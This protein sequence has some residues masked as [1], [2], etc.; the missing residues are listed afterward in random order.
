MLIPSDAPLDFINKLLEE[1][2]IQCLDNNQI[3]ILIRLWKQNTLTYPNI[4]NKLD[5][6]I[7]KIKTGAASMWKIL[8]LATEKDINKSNFKN[9]IIQYMNQNNIS[10]D[11]IIVGNTSTPTH[12]FP[13]K[14]NN[15]N[16]RRDEVGISPI[17]IA[18]SPD[19]VL[20]LKSQFYIQRDEELSAYPVIKQ[21]GGLV[22]IKGSSKSGKTSF[23]SR[24]INYAHGHNY[25]VVTINFHR[26]DDRHFQSVEIFWKW[27]CIY[28]TRELSLPNHLNEYWF[29]ED[30]GSGNA[31]FYF[32][33]YLL[34]VEKEPILLALDRIDYI[35]NYPK[36]SNEFFASLRSWH[37]ERSKKPWDKLHYIIVQ[38]S[39]DITMKKTQ[40]PFNVGV[41]IN[42]QNFSSQ[43]IINLA[44]KH[45]YSWT[46]IE[47]RKLQEIFGDATGHP[48]LIRRILYYLVLNKLDLDSFLAKKLNEL[49]IFA[50][51]VSDN[52]LV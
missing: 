15:Q 49:K 22:R 39:L 27:L 23:M 45:N 40:S 7:D 29:D 51:Y 5:C 32:K 33:K 52:S 19:S 20:P 34:V 46:V 6:S 8:S 31:Y 14:M 42:L 41:E 17:K 38:G 28:A 2:K 10:L 21:D 50:E 9:Q 3:E 48:H 25:K 24:L 44:Q 36:I 13:I 18:E 35:L 1:K 47:I 26:V 4:A 43:Q 37:E 16:E 11:S 12:K 30:S